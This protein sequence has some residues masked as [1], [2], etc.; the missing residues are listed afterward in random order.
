VSAAVAAGILAI[1]DEHEVRLALHGGDRRD[2]ARR[3]CLPL[4]EAAPPC[5]AQATQGAIAVWGGGRTGP[6]RRCCSTG[7]ED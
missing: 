3:R 2:V 1:G 6:A 4:I 7:D 5:R